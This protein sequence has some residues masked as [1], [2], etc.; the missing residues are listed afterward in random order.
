VEAVVGLRS[1]ALNEFFRIVVIIF[2]NVLVCSNNIATNVL[3]DYYNPRKESDGRNT[4]YCIAV[5]GM[6]AR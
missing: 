2:S 6:A 3:S 5:D 4:A 1:Y